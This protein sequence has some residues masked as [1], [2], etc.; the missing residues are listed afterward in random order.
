MAI[1]TEDYCIRAPEKYKNKLAMCEGFDFPI[2]DSEGH[3]I[4]YGKNAVVSDKNEI[5]KGGTKLEGGGYIAI[6]RREKIPEGLKFHGKVENCLLLRPE[7][8]KKESWLERQLKGRRY[9]LVPL[10]DVEFEPAIG[11]VPSRLKF[12][13]E[14]LHKYTEVRI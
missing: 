14:E 3:F 4:G 1:F 8:F 13:K 10:G 11:P 7:E 9:V 12:R 6:R 5:H 2:K